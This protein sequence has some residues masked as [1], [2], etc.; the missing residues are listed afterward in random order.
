MKDIKGYE[1]RYAVTED[2]QIY[3]YYSKNFIYQ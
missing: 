1:G 2:G 3:S